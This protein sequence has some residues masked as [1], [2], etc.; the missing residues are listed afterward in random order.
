[1]LPSGADDMASIGMRF[2][3]AISWLHG[4]AGFWWKAF[5]QPCIDLSLRTHAGL[6][7]RMVERPGTSLAQHELDE[8]V[9]QLRTVAAKTLPAGSLTYGIFS[10]DRE[11]L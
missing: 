1:M 7:T 9:A 6:V 8:L 3:S 5:R 11:R 2:R 4:Q 10:G